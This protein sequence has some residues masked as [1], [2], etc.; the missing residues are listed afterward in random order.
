[1]RVLVKV[2][3]D[4]PVVAIRAALLGGSRRE[5][6]DSAGIF[7]LAA[8][9]L[10]HGTRARSVFDIAHEAD[11]LAGQLDPFSG[12]NSFGLKA[13]FLSK[14]LE[15]GLDLFADILCYPTFPPEEVEKAREDTLGALRL[16]ADN[17][18]AQAFRL[19]EEALYPDHPYGR[20]VLGTPETLARHSA[21]DL[22]RLHA[23]FTRP[24]NLAVAVAGDVDPG[25][26]LEFFGHALAHLAPQGALPPEPPP[27]VP[28]AEPRR[29]RAPA[30]TEQAHVI[31]G[32]LG[33]SIRSADRFALRVANAVLAGQGG[34]LFRRLRDE[35]GLA[36][37]VSSSSVE[38]LDRG[39][40]AGHIATSPANAEAAREGLLAEFEA[41]ARGDVTAEEVEEAKRKLVGSF[42]IALQESFFQA[43]Q[44]ALDEIY[45]L[46]GRSLESYTRAVFAVSMGDAIA[47]AR[48]YF[49]PRGAVSVILGGEEGK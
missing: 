15:D 37:S 6:R 31:A 33:T 17:P 4:V 21:E 32:F 45:G 34:R 12:R 47:A 7:H 40:V 10:V 27:P 35:R 1:V 42:E 38:G 28:L 43:A 48:R 26:V 46:G 20:D 23:A 25:L 8:Q 29:L 3:P 9:T 14:Y 16:R 5:D 22:R 39:Y 49:D 41:L 13:E 2:N 19:F 36:Y 44:L 11:E 30:R 18:A 24:E